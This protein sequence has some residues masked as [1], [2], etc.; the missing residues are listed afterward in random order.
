MHDVVGI[1]THIDRAIFTLNLNKNWLAT[2]LSS[3]CRNDFFS[4]LEE[5]FFSFP[6][7]VPLGRTR[8]AYTS[9]LRPHA[10]VA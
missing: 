3:E 1:G 8:A 5:Y 6:H 7:L 10:L 9:S 2:S 4:F